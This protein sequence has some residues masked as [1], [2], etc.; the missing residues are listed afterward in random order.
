M[1]TQLT[2]L[3]LKNKIMNRINLALGKECRAYSEEL[4]YKVYGHLIFNKKLNEY[5]LISFD[6]DGE[7]ETFRIDEDTIELESPI[8][9]KNGDE[10]Y[11][12]DIITLDSDV[13]YVVEFDEDENQWSLRDPKTGEIINTNDI[14]N[15]ISITSNF[16]HALDV[17]N[18]EIVRIDLFA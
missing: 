16:G 5:M 17:E 13:K 11:E 18:D 3:T 14:K 1:I 6:E 10:I 7:V 8:L 2:K 4:R 9:D 15:N 12:N